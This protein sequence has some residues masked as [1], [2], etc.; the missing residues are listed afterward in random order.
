MNTG[1]ILQG[2]VGSGKSLTAI[3]YFYQK[4]CNGGFDLLN[5]FT[6]LKTPKDLYIITTAKKR[7]SLDWEEE[8]APLCIFNNREKSIQNILLTVDSWNN[9]KK[10]E[11]VENAFFIFDEQR[12]VGSGSWVKSFLNITKK[13]NWIL[14]SATPGDTWLDYIPVFVANGFFK[15]RTDFLRKH[16]VF[17]TYLKFPKVDRYVNVYLLEQYKKKITV[18]M[19][20]SNK[21]NIIRNDITVSYDKDK[22]DL[23]FKKRWNIYKDLP[24]KNVSELFVSMRRV[25]NEDL[26]RL[27]VVNALYEKHKKIIV[28]YNF[29]YELEILR[30]LK[31]FNIILGEHNG[32]KHD[33]IPKGDS[34][35]YL[36]QYTSGSEGWNCVETNVV[37]FYSLNYSYRTMTQA[38]GRIDRLNTKFANLYYY[39]LLSNSP[40]DLAIRKTLNNKKTF[41]EKDFLKGEKI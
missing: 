9:I 36:V 26:S 7:D 21:R 34:W 12:V 35:I 23:I 38:A 16:V 19:D 4:E 10:Y 1:S 31:F 25:C 5:D 20:H 22:Y 37:V 2:G 33:P 18:L 8:A 6:Y 13:N 40:I 11:N 27:A 3:M 24:I 14:L 39:T 41:N 29:N 15:N 30:T 28:F 32:F 17:N